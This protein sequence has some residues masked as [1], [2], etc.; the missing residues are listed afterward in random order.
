MPLITKTSP[1]AAT[2][3]SF[4]LVL[5]ML[6]SP[7][8]C[9]Y[10]L[11]GRSNTL[12]PEVESIGIPL[13]A[14]RTSRPELEQRITEQ[15]IDQFSTRG[16]LYILPGEDGADSVLEGTILSYTTTPVRINEVGRATRYEILLT[17][18]VVLRQVATDRILWEDDHFL[19]SKQYDVPQTTLRALDQEIIAI[20]LVARDF[21]STVVTSILEGF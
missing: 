5:A 2:L 18:R 3:F 9:G 7:A 13:F 21:A 19:F 8:G 20:D 16:R 15:I 4:A 10:R 17:A 12:P 1:P 6:C 11:A 14:N